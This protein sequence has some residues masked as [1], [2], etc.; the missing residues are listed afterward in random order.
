MQTIETPNVRRIEHHPRDIMFWR[1]LLKM[2]I[3][4]FACMFVFAFA[5]MAVLAPFALV[6]RQES[7]AKILVIPMAVIAGA[8]QV[9][10]WGLWAA[11]CSATAAKY[12]AMAEVSHHWLYYVAGFMFCTGPLGYMAHKETQMAQSYDE[13]R[14]IQRGTSLYSLI[15]VVAF[16]VF[17]IRPSL[18][19]WP[20]SW[21]LRFV[22]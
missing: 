4:D 10:F 19:A 16:I 11:F 2:F 6:A 20:Y 22:V 15:A 1:F 18:H 17:C 8:F 5:L 7:P 9:Y 12:S 13:V 21:A 14:G 3:A